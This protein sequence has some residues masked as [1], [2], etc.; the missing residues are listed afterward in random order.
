MLYKNGQIL[1]DW[2]VEEYDNYYEVRVITTD[3]DSLNEK[4][5]NKY[6]KKKLLKL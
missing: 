6:I 1:K 4:Y 2:I 5:Y 3:D